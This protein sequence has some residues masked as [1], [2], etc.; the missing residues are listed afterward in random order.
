LR[1]FQYVSG[2]I[3]ELHSYS[4]IYRV[5]CRGLAFA[6]H[7]LSH[8]DSDSPS[9]RVGVSQEFAVFRKLGFFEVRLY[10]FNKRDTRLKRTCVCPDTDE[11][12]LLPL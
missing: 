1:I 8:D 10:S 9:N 11:E 5:V 7:Q 12:S 3:G 4:K 2:D 6:L